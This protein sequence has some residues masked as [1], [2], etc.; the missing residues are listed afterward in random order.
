MKQFDS[1]LQATEFILDHLVRKKIYS[2]ILRYQ[3]Q[4]ESESMQQKR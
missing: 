1:L 4:A 2:K 3:R